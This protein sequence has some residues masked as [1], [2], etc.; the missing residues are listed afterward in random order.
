MLHDVEVWAAAA[1]LGSHRIRVNYVLPHGVA[2]PRPVGHTG[3]RWP[4]LR[5]AWLLWLTLTGMMLKASHVA[6]AALFLA[7]EESAN[8]SGL[9]LVVDGGIT[10]VSR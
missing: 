5:R 10:F 2:T 8:S 6:E 7:S 1:V 3:R 4:S 9:N